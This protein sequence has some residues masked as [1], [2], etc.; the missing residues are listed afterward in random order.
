MSNALVT[1]VIPSYNYGHFVV[2]AVQSALA[3]TYRPMEVIVVDDGSTDDTRERLRP[4]TDRIHYVYQENRGLSAARNTGIRLARGEWV[5]L[6]DADDI[7][8]P[9]KTDVQLRAAQSL[10]GIGLVGSV[11][12][13]ALPEKLP[14]NPR[15]ERLTVRD[16]LL[17]SRTGPS[18]ALIR[19]N[20]FDVVGLFD[21]SLRSIE[22]RDMWLRISSRFG[23]IQVISPCWWYRPHPGQMSK[24]ASRMVENYTKVLTKF[25]DEHPDHGSL[26]GLAW[27]YCF[28]DGSWSFLAEGDE[29]TARA[30]MW[31]SVILRPWSFGDEQL[32]GFPRARI[33][34]R[35]ALG[36]RL[37]RKLS[38]FRHANL[39]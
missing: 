15:V 23:T 12:V 16:F 38:S 27:S 28:L 9:E 32:K 6:L 2:D 19:R 26:R 21:E 31:K 34:V 18:G 29:R 22:D 8:H 10:D 3:Q 30:L 13:A 39:R 20:C 24:R 36:E 4:F 25:F 5:A 37:F 14:P 17:S 33:I 7:W 35:L 11:P 1:V